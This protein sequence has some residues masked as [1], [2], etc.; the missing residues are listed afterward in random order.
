MLV[1]L[2]TY[3]N[4]DTTLVEVHMSFPSILVI[5]GCGIAFELAAVH[6]EAFVISTLTQV[7]F[8]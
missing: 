5:P 1:K 3:M 2:P 7:H 4:L 8:A 6:M